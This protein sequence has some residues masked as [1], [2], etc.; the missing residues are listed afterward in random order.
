[1]LQALQLDMHAGGNISLATTTHTTSPQNAKGSSLQ[2]Q[3]GPLASISVGQDASIRADGDLTITGAHL[4]IGG[5]FQASVAKNIKIGSVQTEDQKSLERFGGIGNTDVKVQHGSTITVG[6]NTSITSGKDI[7]VEGSQ[8]TLGSTSS[9]QANITAGD[10]ISVSA[11]K[12][13]THILSTNSDNTWHGTNLSRVETHLESVKGS[14]IVSSGGLALSS[15][16]DIAIDGSKVVANRNVQIDAIGDLRIAAVAQAQEQNSTFMNSKNN[17]LSQS[18]RVDKEN[19]TSSLAKES[20]VA[21]LSGNVA[22]KAGNSFLQIGS[23][24][25][26]PQG[27]ISI[28]AKI[29]LS[30]KPV[31]LCL[32]S[33]RI[34]ITNQ[35]SRS[36]S[37][38]H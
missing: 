7:S 14:Q 24:V 1:M 6:K 25:I 32:T 10:S 27:D 22:L 8:L 28:A 11:V 34:A 26:S 30:K 17:L 15:D 23:D 31:K 21:S 18:E 5:D 33:K 36:A 35:G 37:Q 13:T 3:L 4:E 19:V 29:S 9:N 38:T 20:S 12:D 16:Q 2:T